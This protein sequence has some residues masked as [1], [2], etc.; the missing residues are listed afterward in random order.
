[1]GPLVLAAAMAAATEPSYPVE[2]VFHIRKNTNRNQVH[3]AVRVDGD[4]RPLD[5]PVRPYWRSYEEG[6]DAV[7][8]LAPWEQPAYGVVQPE[9]VERGPSSGA[10][11]FRARALPDRPIRVETFRDGEQCRARARMTVAGQPAVLD[12]VEILVAG[13]GKVDRVELFGVA[14]DGAPVH[15]VVGQGSR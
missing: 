1:M 4:C 11:T 15:E 5:A 6:P 10:F 9:A 12:H 13:W 14:A 3:Y 2:S 7:D 8:P